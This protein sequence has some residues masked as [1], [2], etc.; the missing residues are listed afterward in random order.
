MQAVF[1]GLALVSVA[2]TQF[3]L[4]VIVPD[5]VRVVPE[6]LP[7]SLRLYTLTLLLLYVFLALK[8]TSI[9][10]PVLTPPVT[11]AV[12]SDL[13]VSSG[14]TPLNSSVPVLP[15]TRRALCSPV[16]PVK[17]G[18]VFVGAVP[19]KLTIAVLGSIGQLEPVISVLPSL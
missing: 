2:L 14:M 6:R 16:P 9:A 8:V 15:G 12:L 13:L 11:I 3:A 7:R 1:A 19:I 4:K 10:D 18:K 5:K 17:L